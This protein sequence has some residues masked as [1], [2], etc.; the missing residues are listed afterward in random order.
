MNSSNDQNK[1]IGKEIIQGE[2][3]K[4][5]TKQ[6]EQQISGGDDQRRFS[7]RRSDAYFRK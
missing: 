4:L 6:L 7:I 2:I 1:G 5:K 3:G